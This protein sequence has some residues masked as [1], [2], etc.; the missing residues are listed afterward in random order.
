LQ[1]PIPARVPGHTPPPEQARDLGCGG[2]TD[3]PRPARVA[4]GWQP[5]PVGDGPLAIAH[6][7][8]P[9]HARENMLGS[10][11][12][13]VDAGADMIELDLRSTRDGEVVVLHDP[14]LARLWGLDR[15]VQDLDLSA[16]AAVGSGALRVPTLCQV[17][18]TIDRPLM[19]DF[20]GPE[21]VSEALRQVRDAGAMARSLFVSGHLVG[22]GELR[23]A[24]PEARI[25]LTWT[26][27]EG[28][29]AG[30]LADLGAEFWNPAFPL[31]DEEGVAAMHRVGCKVSTWTVD[32][33]DDMRRLITLGVDA[34]ITNR[35]AD[36]LRVLGR[37]GPATRP[38]M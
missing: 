33:S 23:S 21:V 27:P 13:A 5:G 11:E 32:H 22:L 4:P 16:V 12:A 29:S 20:T 8:D 26:R 15:P 10:F 37:P 14:T 34:I 2:L 35:I 25:A 1:V 17:L 7:G 18:R 30:L 36:L 3:G 38:E 9:V 28:P 31:V 24:A 19:L 6:R